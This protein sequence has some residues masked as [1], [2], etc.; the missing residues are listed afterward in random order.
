MWTCHTRLPLIICLLL[1]GAR[2]KQKHAIGCCTNYQAWHYWQW[3]ISRLY[4]NCYLNL[5][6]MRFVTLD[7]SEDSVDI[8]IPFFFTIIWLFVTV[9]NLFLWFSTQIITIR[10]KNTHQEHNDDFVGNYL[11]VYFCCITITL[12]IR[13]Q[14]FPCPFIF[15]SGVITVSSVYNKTIIITCIS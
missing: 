15:G 7:K 9:H 2:C 12:I 14:L 6:R 5:L 10:V 8:S 13:T 11:P 4:S 3:G 1:V